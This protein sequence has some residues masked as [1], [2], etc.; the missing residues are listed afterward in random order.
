MSSALFMWPDELVGSGR[1][2]VGPGSGQ[3]WQPEVNVYE[4][5]EGLLLAFAVPGVLQED[6]EVQVTGT[7]LTVQG[8]RDL[9]VPENANPQRIELRK[10]RFSRR[11]QLPASADETSIRTQLLHGLLLIHVPK[12]PP[13]RIKVEGDG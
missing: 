7:L 4:Y 13:R 5:P 10:G 9:P 1:P 6:I 12:T 11:V 8:N 2:G 3:G